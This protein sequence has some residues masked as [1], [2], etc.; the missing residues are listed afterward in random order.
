MVEQKAIVNLGSQ[1]LFN[2]AIAD[3]ENLIMVL[4][5]TS[6]VYAYITRAEIESG[7]IILTKNVMELIRSKIENCQASGIGPDLTTL[8]L[9]SERIYFS[10][11][12]GRRYDVAISNIDTVF[13]DSLKEETGLAGSWRVV[14]TGTLAHADNW[15]R[16]RIFFDGA[17]NPD[18]TGTELSL[19]ENTQHD[20]MDIAIESSITRNHVANDGFDEKDIINI[21]PLECRYLSGA[22]KRWIERWMREV[23]GTEGDSY[24]VKVA[25]LPSFTLA[26][27]KDGEDVLFKLSLDSRHTEFPKGDRFEL[28]TFK[29]KL[30][31]VEIPAEEE[32]V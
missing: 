6:S 3:T 18:K 1:V 7:G 31:L 22:A 29:L 17:C 32:E 2:N 12:S 24:L 26:N 14:G 28:G 13:R 9:N 30:G 25:G 5:K 21:F 4:N 20:I 19:W 27:F 23:A 10:T 8:V 11:L 16:W 15:G